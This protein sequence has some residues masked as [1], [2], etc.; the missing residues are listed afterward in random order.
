M[1]TSAFL[2]ALGTS[3]S[4]I[5]G[6][7]GATGKLG[8][9]PVITNEPPGVAY[10]AVLPNSKT[11]SVR[12]S[13]T[14][15]SNTNGTGVNFNVNFYGFPDMSLGP[16]IYHIHNEPVPSDG[17]CTGTTAH[18]DPYVRGEAPPCDSTQPET[19][20][21]GDLAGKHG[22]ITVSPFQSAYLDL[23]LSTSP[24]SNAFFGNRSVVVHSSNAT[25]LTCAN[26]T[27]VATNSSS[28]SSIGG[29]GGPTPGVG[30]TGLAASG[31]TI[32]FV[33]VVGALF[34]ALFL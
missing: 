4:L 24:S 13:I 11:T 28:N 18:L 27:L 7:L 6:S 2:L 29:G 23:Y 34:A 15:V 22:N 31:T 8:D 20:Q 16:F 30:Y 26:F 1:F 12:G 19:C 9:A 33:A 10:Q 32:S 21:V 17:N 25:R 5:N 3:L 14:G